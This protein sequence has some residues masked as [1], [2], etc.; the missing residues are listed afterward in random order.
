MASIDTKVLFVRPKCRCKLK[1]FHLFICGLYLLKLNML[2]VFIY[3]FFIYYF[4][5]TEPFLQKKG[6]PSPKPCLVF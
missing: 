3:L 1:L 4:K 2:T 5:W 6:L